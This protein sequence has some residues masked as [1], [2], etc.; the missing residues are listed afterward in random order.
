MGGRMTRSYARQSPA[1]DW[2]VRRVGASAMSVERLGDRGRL[3]RRHGVGV[4][5]AVADEDGLV[6]RERDG[7][8]AGHRPP[9]EVGT[10]AGLLTL[11]EGVDLGTFV[12]L[13][14]G[15]RAAGTD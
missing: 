14:L 9:A 6:L 4:G 12:C 7:L 15:R 10:P 13:E 5:A 1:F 11:V 3:V 8:E 2:P